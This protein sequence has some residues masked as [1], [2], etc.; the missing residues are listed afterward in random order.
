MQSRKS[1]SLKFIEELCVITMKNDAE[2]LRGIDL[3]FQS[4]HK[5]FYKFWPEHLKVSKIWTL[6]FQIKKYKEVMFDG[7]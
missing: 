7:T 4:W 5:K 3:S 6:M 2:F 1:M